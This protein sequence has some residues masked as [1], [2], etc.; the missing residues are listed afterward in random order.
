MSAFLIG[1]RGCGKTTIGKRLA[2]RLWQRF[3]DSDEMVA[4]YAG[5][6]IRAIFEEE[7]EPVF[8]AFETAVLHELVTMQE[9]VI[10]LGGGVI[11]SPENRQLIKRSGFKVIYM[12]CAPDELWR[13]IQQDPNTA[14]NRPHLTELGGGLAE[15]RRLIEEREPLYRQCMTAELDV[16]FLSPQDCTTYI[17]RML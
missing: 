12:K 1:Y 14:D 13:R 3:V 10:S 16:T 6:S 8:R 11:L 7:G 2:D 4:R 17:A 15:I 5:K 9:H